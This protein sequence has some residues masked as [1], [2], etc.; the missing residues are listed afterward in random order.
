MEVFG[1]LK[2]L[3]NLKNFLKFQGLKMGAFGQKG[4][5]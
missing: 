2:I 3:E 4:L 5:K 1:G